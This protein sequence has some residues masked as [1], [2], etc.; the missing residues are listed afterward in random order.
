ML[1][2]I[3]PATG[4]LL[5]EFPEDTAESVAKK[6]SKAQQAQ[7]AWAAL[8]GDARREALVAFRNMLLEKRDEL[9]A[10]L[11]SETGKPIRQSLSEIS[12][13]AERLDFFVD[14]FAAVI[15][16][17]EVFRYP[18]EATPDPQGPTLEERITYEPLGVIANISAWNFPY[19]VGTNVIAPALLTGNAVLYKPSELATSTGLLVTEMLHRAG[20]PKDVFQAVVGGPEA[21]R[22]VLEQEL[23]G[24]FFTGSHDTG[25]QIAARAAVGMMRIQLELGGKDPVYVCEDINV[26][27]VAASVADGAFYN[28]GQ[29]CCA[30]ERVYVH[31]RLY[32]PFLEAFVECVKAFTVGDPSDEKTFV[33]PVARPGQLE[34]LQHQVQDALEKGASVV[35]GGEPVEGPGRFF[36][37]TILV[38]V[39]HTMSVMRDESFGPVIGIKEVANDA[40]AISL[41]NDTRYGLTAAVYTRDG[42][43]ARKILGALQTGTVYWNCCD[44]ISPRLPWTGRKHSGVGSTLSVLGIRAFVTPKA[45]H[46]KSVC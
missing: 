45:W 25:V 43:R 24:V 17:D 38:N 11:T 3:N 2:V 9:G 39:D 6:F 29:S 35:L 8:P 21:G 14:N 23:G 30:V 19:F 27:A 41:M 12:T 4:E 20:V 10:T 26:E 46:L 40:E 7:P 37:P 32:K 1:Q 5:R 34:A 13:T 22:L 15:A 28:T 44:R 16:P 33:G 18:S 42:N 36:A 31:K